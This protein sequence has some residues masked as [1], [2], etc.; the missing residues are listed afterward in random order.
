MGTPEGRILAGYY[1]F[2]ANISLTF[3]AIKNLS[4]HPTNLRF[5]HFYKCFDDFWEYLE[6]NGFSQRI[7]EICG[8]RNM[9]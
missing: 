6:I 1:C 4:A 5:G 8:N 9:I 3:Q 2:N 7:S